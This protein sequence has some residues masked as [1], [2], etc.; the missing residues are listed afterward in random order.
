MVCD[1]EPIFNENGKRPTL[2]VQY[3]A[4]KSDWF[5]GLTF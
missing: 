5:F 3:Y 4:K 1:N 2:V